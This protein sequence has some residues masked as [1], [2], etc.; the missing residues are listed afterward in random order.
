MVS[1]L[2]LALALPVT[3][4]YEC[5]SQPH[6][7]LDGPGTTTCTPSSDGWANVD[8]DSIGTTDAT[9]ATDGQDISIEFKKKDC[10]PIVDDEMV[11]TGSQVP[12]TLA[13]RTVHGATVGD[14]VY[15]QING[16][17]VLDCA[18]TDGEKTIMI[19]VTRPAEITEF[20]AEW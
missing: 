8:M 1:A 17:Y 6:V 12:C 7:E 18:Q 20:G 9:G 14:F 19:K 3:A 10:C 13:D 11:C 4:T 15:Q 2:F 16:R 5:F